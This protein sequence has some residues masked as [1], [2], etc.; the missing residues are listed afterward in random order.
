MRVLTAKTCLWDPLAIRH[1]QRE[2][3]FWTGCL[4]PCPITK[5]HAV[6]SSSEIPE[7]QRSCDTARHPDIGDQI[8]QTQ[9]NG[10][11]KVKVV[12]IGWNRLKSVEIGW[13]RLKSVEISWNRLK[14][15]E[16]GW[17]RLNYWVGVVWGDIPT[18]PPKE[19][20]EGLESLEGSETA[21][22]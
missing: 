15:V 22:P 1:G 2:Y 10:Q 13:N 3:E 20:L 14:S 7:I 17:N 19:G 6:P 12:E 21:Q 18:H 9:R 11:A 8:F 16:I 5:S 4:I